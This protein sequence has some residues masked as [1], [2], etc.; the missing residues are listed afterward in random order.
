ML[1]FLSFLFETHF[2]M[3]F[4]LL[5]S[6]LPRLKGILKVHTDLRWEIIQKKYTIPGTWSWSSEMEFSLQCFFFVNNTRP[7][8]TVTCQNV[9]CEKKKGL[10]WPAT[11]MLCL[12]LNGLDTSTQLFPITLVGYH[13]SG[14]SSFGPWWKLHKVT[15]LHGYRVLWHWWLF[16]IISIC[17]WTDDWLLMLFMSKEGWRDIDRGRWHFVIR[18]CTILVHCCCNPANHMLTQLY[19]YIP[20]LV[21][22]ASLLLFLIAF[23]NGLN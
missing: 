21:F 10:L 4:C 8:A 3:H 14:W 20:A 13:L 2:K 19:A 16:P 1:Q 17:T 22:P 5:S 23:L 15:K 11:N 12:D 18:T 9:I 6:L 7:F